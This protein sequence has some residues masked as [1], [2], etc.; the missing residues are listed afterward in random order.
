MIELNVPLT[1]EQKVKAEFRN[2]HEKT[3]YTM[4]SGDL[5]YPFPHKYSTSLR[6]FEKIPDNEVKSYEYLNYHFFE[7]KAKLD[8]ERFNSYFQQFYTMH[9]VLN[10]DKTQNR[11]KKYVMKVLEYMFNNK[12]YSNSIFCY[13]GTALSTGELLMQSSQ[14]YIKVSPSEV[15]TLWK[16]RTSQ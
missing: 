15:L 1:R 10:F 9:R 14:K 7:N 16:Q 13:F 3:I 8:L 6:E 11:D 2:F 4:I 5:S 12:K